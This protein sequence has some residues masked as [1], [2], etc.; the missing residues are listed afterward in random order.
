MKIKKY[1]FEI[2]NLFDSKSSVDD[3]LTSLQEKGWKVKVQALI[4][5]DSS[6]FLVLTKKVKI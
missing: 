2:I 1:K 4:N 5:G 6:I 3:K